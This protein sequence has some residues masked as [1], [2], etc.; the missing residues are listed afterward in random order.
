[1]GTVQ[2]VDGPRSLVIGPVGLGVR[3][4]AVEVPKTIDEAVSLGLTL[5]L[6]PDAVATVR[7]LRLAVGGT[8]RVVFVMSVGGRGRHSAAYQIAARGATADAIQ[9]VVLV[10]SACDVF[11]G[12]T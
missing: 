4:E 3:K 9:H 12:L 11:P 6:L 7:H 8:C 1:M 2:G 10:A 5:L